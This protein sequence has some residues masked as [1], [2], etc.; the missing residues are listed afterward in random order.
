MKGRHISRKAQRNLQ[1][2]PK[3][4][5]MSI[6]QLTKVI[7]QAQALIAQKGYETALRQNRSVVEQGQK[8]SL[9]LHSLCH[10]ST[11]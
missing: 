2:A 6:N 1:S 7:D 8:A 4:E 5:D 11:R 9:Q 10:F 3:I